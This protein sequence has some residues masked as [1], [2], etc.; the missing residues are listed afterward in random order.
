MIRKLIDLARRLRKKWMV[1][2]PSAAHKPRRRAVAAAAR[3]LLAA[4]ITVSVALLLGILLGPVAHWATVGSDSL[5]GK[6]KADAINATRQVLLAAAGGSAVVVGLGFTARSYF[7][8]KRGQFTDR[9]TKAIGQLASEKLTER[10]GGIYSLEHLMR[11]SAADHITVIDVL[12]AFIRENAPIAHPTSFAEPSAEQPAN[13]PTSD[14][15]ETPKPSTDIQAALTVLARR[16]KRPEPLGYINLSNTD[17]RR[18]DLRWARFDHVRLERT[19]LQHANL[20]HANLEGAVLRQAQLQHA[21][22]VGAKMKDVGLIDARLEHA[23]LTMARL[24]WADLRRAQ[25]QY[26]NLH[27]AELQHALLTGACLREA[28]LV[29]ALLQ[30][31][32]LAGG[33]TRDW[34]PIDD[35]GVTGAQLHGADI[36]AAE[37][38]GANLATNFDNKPAPVLGLTIEQLATARWDS[39]TSLPADLQEA[40][41]SHQGKQKPTVDPAG[42][43]QDPK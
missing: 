40:L 14:A 39:T 11:E 25:L 8:S 42:S 27:L 1:T 37:L 28:S 13:S 18:A 29:H 34:G 3:G 43:Q 31:T 19:W 22:L 7:L 41:T 36:K 24:T 12:A 20:A 38:R 6:E 10:L 17:L 4:I 30:H 9:Y 32:H 21:S 15:D 23:N 2:S 26:A 16:P 35:E 33:R 5:A